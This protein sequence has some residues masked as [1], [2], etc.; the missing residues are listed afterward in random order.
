MDSLFFIFLDNQTY[1][2][3]EQNSKKGS[4]AVLAKTVY[5]H[6]MENT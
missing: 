6:K 1:R 2:I 3:R 4:S 5:L